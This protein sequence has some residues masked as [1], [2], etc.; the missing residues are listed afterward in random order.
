MEEQLNN[1]RK[2]RVGKITQNFF[3][4]IHATRVHTFSM[5]PTYTF[6]LGMILGFLFL[7]MVF[8]GVI[9]MI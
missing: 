1:D 3:L 9:L 6:G 4:H 5:K 2:N 8:T 7:I